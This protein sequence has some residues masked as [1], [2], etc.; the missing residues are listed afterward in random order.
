MNK[1]PFLAP[2]GTALPKR[3]LVL[4]GGGMRVAYQ[5]GVLKALEEEGLRFF[6]AD[7]TSGGTINLAMLFSGLSSAEMCE[8]WRQLNVKDFVSFLSPME[9][10]KAMNLEAMGDASGLREKIFPHLGVDMDAL[11]SVKAMDGTF[12][13]CNFTRKVNV[14]ISHREMDMDFL[15]AGV[16]L[17]ILLPPIEKQGQLYMDSVW[18]KD[19]NVWESVKRGAEE[20][21]LVWCIGNSPEYHK[22]AFNQYVHMIELSANG[23]LFE[24]FDRIRELNERIALGDSP[25]GQRRPIRLHVIK[26][27]FPLPLDPEFYFN[28]IDAATLINQGYADAKGYL[29]ARTESGLPF[30]PEATAMK[31]QTLGLT[32]RETMAGPFAMGETDP[33]KGAE[34]GKAT[35]IT[36]NATVTIDDLEEFQS[37]PDHAGKLA[38]HIDFAP[39][40]MAIPA[41]NGVFKLF[42]PV[43]DPLMKFM[44]YE[45]GFTHQGQPYYLAGHKEVKDDPGFDLWK[46]T[47]T[48]YTTLHRGIDKSGPVVGAGIMSLSMGDFLKLISTVSAIGSHGA[49]ESLAAVSAFGTFFLGKLWEQYG[50]SKIG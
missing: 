24:E 31:T 47:T 50:A 8:R 11:R 28:R 14:A 23:V 38:G 33:R 26:P 21:W 12:N 36:M 15:I 17:P 13:V 49:K 9:Y 37:S 45:L 1:V 3:S 40:G 27:E 20:I 7:G 5:A 4:A 30:S 43:E 25:Y 10:L 42:S 2:E 6:H 39:F 35:P 44:V 22:G 41:A 34:K 18:I 29:L 19:A 48:L 32:F 46:D 16:S